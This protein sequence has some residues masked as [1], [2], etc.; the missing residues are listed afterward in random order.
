MQIIVAKQFNTTTNK[1]LKVTLSIHKD[2]KSG[3]FIYYH[4][5]DYIDLIKLK[6]PVRYKVGQE[7]A[8][9]NTF[10]KVNQNLQ[11]LKW[12]ENFYALKKAG[13]TYFDLKAVY[14][15]E[16]NIKKANLDIKIKEQKKN[17]RYS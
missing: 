6:S 4:S 13:C 8:K 14:N 12:A 3:R 16:R 7:I 9:K 15:V 17:K 1:L 5:F 11:G 2:K 10:A